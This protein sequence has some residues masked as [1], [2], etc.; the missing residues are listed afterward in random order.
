[1][2]VL[3]AFI[4]RTAA[5]RKYRMTYDRLRQLERDGKLQRFPA[6]DVG[7]SHDKPHARGRE[8]KWVY[9]EEDVAKLAGTKADARFARMARI[10]AH[11]FDLLST[12]H[13][14]VEIIRRTRIDYAE[15][16][17]LR[18]I[19]VRE[20]GVFVIPREAL[21]L[22]AEHGLELKPN[23]IGPLF[24]RLLEAAR[25]NNRSKPKPRIPGLVPE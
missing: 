12:G 13:D 2:G 6:K 19:Y 24:V 1:M 25:A 5:A 23:T 7:Y 21:D 3:M 18:N 8:V 17:R 16:T 9:N 22:A 20:K 10:D 15:A 4:S 11:V 14:L